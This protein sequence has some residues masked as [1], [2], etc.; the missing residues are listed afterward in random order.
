MTG[1]VADKEPSGTTCCV[2]EVRVL[3]PLFQSGPVSETDGCVGPYQ[4]L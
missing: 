4:M 2:C 3:C 1:E